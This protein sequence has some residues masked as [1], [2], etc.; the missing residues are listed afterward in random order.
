MNSSVGI[1]FVRREMNSTRKT[2]TLV[3]IL[4]GLYLFWMS[5][6][7]VHLHGDPVTGVF[8]NSSPAGS[9]FPIPYAPGPLMMLVLA[10]PLDSSLYLFLFKY[11][12]WIVLEILIILYIAMPY[13]L[14]RSNNQE[15]QME[16]EN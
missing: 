9:L 15:E 12:T 13:T 10:S 4:V 1:R 6:V 2:I 7:A 14:A 3:L 5:T 11:G 16:P 8:W